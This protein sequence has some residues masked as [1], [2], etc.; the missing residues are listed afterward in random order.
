MGE[1]RRTTGEANDP[2]ARCQ[3]HTSRFG[4][5]PS[6]RLHENTQVPSA[7]EKSSQNA[8]PPAPAPHITST[9]LPS[10]VHQTHTLLLILSRLPLLL[11]R[12]QACSTVSL[13][14]N[15]VA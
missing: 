2:P 14:S 5:S 8:E 9:A 7:L 10:F 12:A 3:V 1:L 6:C 13:L 4:K 11:F 15:S